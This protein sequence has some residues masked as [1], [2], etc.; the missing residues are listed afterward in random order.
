LNKTVKR[1]LAKSIS[2]VAAI[3]ALSNSSLAQ[4]TTYMPIITPRPEVMAA[5]RQ[6]NMQVGEYLRK[7]TTKVVVNTVVVSNS[8]L[9]LING[10]G[11]DTSWYQYG[12]IADID[13]TFSLGFQI[14]SNEKALTYPTAI[15]GSKIKALDVLQLE[16]E[17]T[18][19]VVE[20]SAKRLGCITQTN[21]A[22]RMVSDNSKPTISRLAIVSKAKKFIGLDKY[23]KFE[24]SRFLM[25]TNVA[26]AGSTSVFTE[27][28]TNLANAFNWQVYQVVS[29]E[30]KDPIYYRSSGS[31]ADL[32]LQEITTT[33]IED[34]T[35]KGGMTGGPELNGIGIYVVDTNQFVVAGKNGIMPMILPK[36]L[37]KEQK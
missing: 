24:G 21:G 36:E 29:P 4:N 8:C 30:V 5:A 7:D 37:S 23:A 33:H 22:Y 16:L 31:G 2:T 32:T 35:T 19:G 15:A 14:W 26:A 1:G 20:M 28:T 34:I 18:N 13:G 27:L 9:S 11:D 3:V 6:C 25:D 10:L 12:V 17:L